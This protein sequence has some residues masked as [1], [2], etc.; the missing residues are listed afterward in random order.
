MATTGSTW[1]RRLCKNSPLP[2]PLGMNLGTY[3]IWDGRYFFL[4]QAILVV[5]L[6]NYEVMFLKKTKILGEVYCK[7]CLGYDFVCSIATHT[8]AGGYQGGGVLLVTR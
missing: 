5:H 2:P 6:G 1:H 4:L 8:A 3:N 7:K